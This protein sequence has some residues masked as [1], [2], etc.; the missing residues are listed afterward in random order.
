MGYYTRFT[1]E[2]TPE[3]VYT[4]VPLVKVL[5]ANVQL[6]DEDKDVMVTAAVNIRENVIEILEAGY[7]K[8]LF[9]DTCKWYEH[10]EDMKKVSSNYPDVIF[11]LEGEGEEAGDMWKK[12]FMNGKMQS[13]K[14]V[15][16]YPEFDAY[17]LA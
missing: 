14:A 7:G 6:V 9:E 4:E 13:C 1:L 2:I 17:L 15:I 5:K 3:Y 11:T 16:T 10:E 12:Y 8:G